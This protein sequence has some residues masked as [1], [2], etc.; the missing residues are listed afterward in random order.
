MKY[1]LGESFADYGFSFLEKLHS[2]I[3]LIHRTGKLKKVNEA[4]RKLLSVLRLPKRQLEE[5]G[6]SL[7][8]ATMNAATHVGYRRVETPAG[9]LRLISK[10][11]EHSDYV[12]VEVVR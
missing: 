7:A 4:G 8:L 2:P 9:G 6:T 5:F 10:H 1:S 11:L 3:F 12:L